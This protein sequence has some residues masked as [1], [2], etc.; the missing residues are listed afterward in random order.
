MW[1]MINSLHAP[2]RKRL[3]KASPV[4][5]HDIIMAINNTIK[6]HPLLM[7]PL[8]ST[9][10][11]L[12][13]PPELG[14]P[15][16]TTALSNRTPKTTTAVSD[17]AVENYWTNCLYS[18]PEKSSFLTIVPECY[19][20]HAQKLWLLQDK[21]A[22]IYSLAA[23]AGS[24]SSGSWRSYTTALMTYQHFTLFHNNY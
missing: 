18:P 2:M 16:S 22:S 13:L 3:F 14:P 15:T 7:L 6:M 10:K 21:S 24:P 4:C 8:I 17:S 5:L 9:C 19:S 1:V 23:G 12:R 20:V 11:D